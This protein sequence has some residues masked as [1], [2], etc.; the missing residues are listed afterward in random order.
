MALT[1]IRELYAITQTVAKWRNYL[2]GRRFN[3]RTD[4]QSLKELMIQVILTPKQQYYMTKLLRYDYD[5]PYRLRKLNW[6]AN[7]LSRKV[8]QSSL[9]ACTSITFPIL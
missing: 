8:E 6:V 1:Y 4:H 3:I 9:C 2:L 5:I 7:A